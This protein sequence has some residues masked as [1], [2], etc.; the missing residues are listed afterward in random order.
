MELNED[1]LPLH[2]D[3]TFKLRPRLFLEGNYFVDLKPGSPNARRESTTDHT[4]PV[5][6]TS[7]S[8]QLDQVLTTLQADVRTDLQTFLDQFG[9]A[10]DQARRRRGLPRA[11]PDLGRRPASTPRRSTR[12][13]SGPSPATSRADPR[14]RPGRPRRSGATRARCRTWSPTSGSS[15]A[16]SRPRTWRWARRSSSCP[17][18]LDGG[19]PGVREP[20]RRLPAAARLRPRGPARRARRRRTR[21]APRRRSSAGPRARLRARAA[22]PGRR[23]APDDPELA[24]LAHRTVPFLEQARALSSLLQRGRDPLVQRHRRPGR[25]GGPVPASSPS[26]ASSRRPPTGSAGS[27]A[28][29]ARA[30]PTASTSGSWPAAARTR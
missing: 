22:R 11:L 16:R 3:A 14:P 4:F 20:Q 25:A 28:R 18:T 1:A 24:E 12:R 27:P 15:P 2:E 7:Y 8:V 23:P 29:A 10:L 19:A 6:Q 17:A 9:N 30:T 26:A 21:C 13:C 5:N